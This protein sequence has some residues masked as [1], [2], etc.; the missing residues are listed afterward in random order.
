MKFKEEIQEKAETELKLEEESK[1]KVEILEEISH[2]KEIQ[3]VL[4]EE[5][6]VE[7]ILVVEEKIEKIQHKEVEKEHEL[8][9]IEKEISLSEPQE[10][11]LKDREILSSSEEAQEKILKEKKE[12]EDV[13]ESKEKELDDTKETPHEERKEV[14][15]ISTSEEKVEKEDHEAI[16]EQEATDDKEILTSLHTKESVVKEMEALKDISESKEKIKETEK[17]LQ[18]KDEKEI[19]KRER[20]EIQK[21]SVEKQEIKEIH[22]AEVDVEK[23]IETMKEKLGAKDEEKYKEI[24]SIAELQEKAIKYGKEISDI[25]ETEQKL[26]EEPT[27]EVEKALIEEGKKEV[28]KQEETAFSTEI[29]DIVTVEKKEVEEMVKKEE[30]KDKKEEPKPEDTEEQIISVAEEQ[31]EALRKEEA[32]PSVEHQMTVSEEIE[33]PK[34]VTKAKE[35]V[36]EVGKESEETETHVSKETEILKETLTTSEIDKKILVQEKQIE[37]PKEEIEEQSYFRVKEPEGK[38]SEKEIELQKQTIEAETRKEALEAEIE[39]KGVSEM[40]EKAEEEISEEKY[41]IEDG[42]KEVET[43]IK[44]KEVETEIEIPT[45]TKIEEEVPDEKREPVEILV[46]KDKADKKEHEDLKYLEKEIVSLTEAKEKVIKDEK[47][48]KDKIEEEQKEIEETHE[49]DDMKKIETQEEI[50]LAI[51]KEKVPEVKERKTDETDLQTKEKTREE[52]IVAQEEHKEIVDILEISEAKEILREETKESGAKYVEEKDIL[53]PSKAQEIT[54]DEKKELKDVSEVKEEIVVE[55]KETK[56][57]EDKEKIEIQKEIPPYEEIKEST[58]EAKDK[59]KE[60]AEVL[61]EIKEQEAKDS[62]VDDKEIK[63]KAM[64]KFIETKEEIKVSLEGEKEK[65]KTDIIVQEKMPSEEIQEKVLQTEKEAEKVEEEMDKT[66]SETEDKELKVEQEKKDVTQILETKKESQEDEIIEEDQRPSSP[67]TSGKDIT[68]TAIRTLEEKSQ[69]SEKKEEITEREVSV[70]KDTSVIGEEEKLESKDGEKVLKSVSAEVAKDLKEI[71][72]TKEFTTEVDKEETI[73]VSKEKETQIDVEKTEPKTVISEKDLEEMQQIKDPSFK[74][75]ETREQDEEI[76]LVVDKGKEVP[77]KI[78]GDKGDSE[79]SSALA[80]QKEVEYETLKETV[81]KLTEDKLDDKLKSKDISQEGKEISDEKTHAHVVEKEVSEEVLSKALDEKLVSKDIQVLVEKEEKDFRDKIVEESST[82]E[83][84]S[85]EK[86]EEIVEKREHEVTLDKQIS[87]EIAEKETIKREI[88]TDIVKTKDAEK[89]VDEKQTSKEEKMVEDDIT[90]ELIEKEDKKSDAKSIIS[91]DTMIMLGKE[92]SEEEI[93]KTEGTEKSKEAEEKLDGQGLAKEGK[94]LEEEKDKLQKV[95]FSKIV[96]DDD[97]KDGEETVTLSEKKDDSEDRG[98]VTH[99]ILE[100]TATTKEIEIVQLEDKMKAED[101]SHTDVHLKHT[102][103]KV[104]IKD[105][106]GTSVVKGADIKSEEIQTETT[107][108][109]VIEKDLIE[110]IDVKETTSLLVDKEKKEVEE[111]IKEDKSHTILEKIVV[112]EEPITIIEQKEKELIVQDI[113]SEIT[114]TETSIKEKGEKEAKEEKEKIK[115][116]KEELKEESGVTESV[117]LVKGTVLDSQELQKPELLEEREEKVEGV[118]SLEETEE[119][120]GEIHSESKFIEHIEEVVSQEVKIKIVAQASKKII[121]TIPEVIPEHEATTTTFSSSSV[122]T[123][124]GTIDEEPLQI[125]KE[126]SVIQSDSESH[127]PIVEET[128]KPSVDDEVDYALESVSSIS[129]EKSSCVEKISKVSVETYETESLTTISSQITSTTKTSDISSRSVEKIQTEFHPETSQT[130]DS[131]KID[132]VKHTD[133]KLIIDG[134]KDLT[135]VRSEVEKSKSPISLFITEP[136][137]DVP[138]STDEEDEKEKS[139]ESGESLVKIKTESKT[140]EKD[141]TDSSTKESKTEVSSVVTKKHRRHS[142][143]SSSSEKSKDKKSK[144]KDT[145]S[146]CSSSEEQDQDQKVKTKDADLGSSSSSSSSKT[147]S[148]SDSNEEH[149]EKVKIKTHKTKKHFSKLSGSS[150]TNTSS[151]SSSEEVIKEKRKV[152]TP[153]PKEKRR[154]SSKPKIHSKHSKMLQSEKEYSTIIKSPTSEPTPHEDDNVKFETIG[155]QAPEILPQE[156]SHQMLQDTDEDKFAQTLVDPDE[157]VLDD[158]SLRETQLHEDSVSEVMSQSMFIDSK[159]LISK[160]ITESPVYDILKVESAEVVTVSSDTT[161]ASTPISPKPPYKHISEKGKEYLAKDFIADE[162][163]AEGTAAFVGRNYDLMT[164]SIC[165]EG[166]VMTSSMYGDDFEVYGVAGPSESHVQEESFTFLSERDDIMSA[167]VYGSLIESDDVYEETKFSQNLEEID[168][169][170]VKSPREYICKEVIDS[171]RPYSPKSDTTVSDV[172]GKEGLDSLESYRAQEFIESEKPISARSDMSGKSDES[173]KDSAFDDRD[174]PPSLDYQRTT[175]SSESQTRSITSETLKTLTEDESIEKFSSKE[176]EHLYHEY[177]YD[178]AISDKSEKIDDKVER[179]ISSIDSLT[180]TSRSISQVESEEVAKIDETE[181]DY[182]SSESLSKK[183][184]SHESFTESFTKTSSSYK[185]VSSEETK[186]FV[187]ITEKTTVVTDVK[188]TFDPSVDSDTRPGEIGEIK[189]EIKSMPKVIT[190]RT[191]VCG[192]EPFALE[193]EDGDDSRRKSFDQ[194][195]LSE[196]VEHS[197]FKDVSSRYIVKRSVSDKGEESSTKH[198]ISDKTSEGDEKSRTLVKRTFYSSCS[199]ES[200]ASKEISTSFVKESYSYPSSTDDSSLK[201]AEK[202]KEILTESKPLKHEPLADSSTLKDFSTLSSTSHSYIKGQTETQSSEIKEHV[203]SQRESVVTSSISSSK[204]QDSSSRIIRKASSS[205]A[206][207]TPGSPRTGRVV[208]RKVTTVITKYY[209]DGEEVEMEEIPGSEVVEVLGSGDVTE[210]ILRKISGS[211]SSSPASVRR[212]TIYQEEFDDQPVYEQ[213]S[214]KDS[215][216][217]SVATS[218]EKHLTEE[219]SSDPKKTLEQ[220]GKPLGLPSPVPAPL[221]VPEPL[222]TSSNSQKT[223]KKTNKRSKKSSSPVYLDLAY[224]PHAA[225]PNYAGVE[226]FKRVRARYY[227]FSGIDPGREV[228]NALLQAKMEWEDKDMEVTIIPTYDTD[229]LGYW[230]AANEEALIANKIDL[231]PS[232]IRCTI[233][234][235]DHETS[236]NAYRLEF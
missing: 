203:A 110:K 213:F 147:K 219:G 86:V 113:E 139:V 35:K 171:G 137:F 78:L 3:K 191:T 177:K 224:V 149:A 212:V 64:E 156:P 223:E 217:V 166:D 123:V 98:K 116:T 11:D 7:K 26:V 142:S 22:E 120:K 62:E 76:T 163:L 165:Y 192:A 80:E 42:P 13:L 151:D 144:T 155:K 41:E 176:T 234:L 208:V 4:E 44:P 97:T 167:S 8:K 70:L 164:T 33:K 49:K 140:S 184:T 89:S 111:E 9:A 16:S 209:E 99:E 178:T 194:D 23:E 100:E 93:L 46:D 83:K 10:K 48:L 172:V 168:S 82:K 25:Q 63:D 122:K 69:E 153:K 160:D 77:E 36:V 197:M 236:C 53:S 31:E 17:I 150:K 136:S 109:E 81:V 54:S 43:E 221:P 2:T 186:D 215:S 50:S 201:S 34:D 52:P 133:E 118:K 141:T 211:A 65:L 85:E 132:D 90:I 96:I 32:V 72:D 173:G 1:E 94:L 196:E 67:D 128:S 75:I 87:P 30:Y 182:L 18:E 119:R 134:S 45:T 180:K 125:I 51:E 91:E 148:S 216:S 161:P 108:I 12:S 103:V 84:E 231:A 60:I 55:L 143:A 56:E 146:S 5:K 6:E 230:V 195:D 207:G 127:L 222:N 189:R 131:K 59:E 40:K 58:V 179:A 95:E 202:T 185:I 229:A 61:K 28:K 214:S 105:K 27:Q 170:A 187:Q 175:G 73:T 158:H 15:D 37:I 157:K 235:Q 183:E 114:S 206:E 126:E 220:W 193:E 121:E 68:E 152:R 115:S 92:V 21:V 174:K 71:S 145:E 39:V 232:A 66:K 124:V 204:D 88:L 162:E 227:V 228:L 200:L 107:K 104:E 20:I 106:E 154:R 198:E 226:Y 117:S 181:K 47:E 138:Q 159:D 74:K 102:D 190:R 112:A 38:D 205:S 101:I 29:E 210:D 233:N 24:L 188:D 225:N 169:K 130:P 79:D 218:E 135:K 199:P 14:E 19:D 129:K 57:K